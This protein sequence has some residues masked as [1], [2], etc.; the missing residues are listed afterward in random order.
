MD[1]LKILYLYPDI[2]ELYGDYGNIQVLKYRLES[3]GIQC[4][5]VP[6]SIGDDAPDF[7]K[8]DLVF[9]GGGA[10]L[11]QSVLANDLMKLKDTIKLAVDNRRI[12]S[13]NLW[14]IPIIW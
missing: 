12:F 8:F 6:Y 11:E 7:T 4:E 1:T 3:R 9:A 2:L 5:I 13:I 14:C 10:D